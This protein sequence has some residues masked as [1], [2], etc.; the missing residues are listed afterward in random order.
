MK[1]LMFREYGNK[2]EMYYLNLIQRTA[3][4]NFVLTCCLIVG[5]SIFIIMWFMSIRGEK[6]SNS[7]QKQYRDMYEP[8]YQSLSYRIL[9]FLLYLM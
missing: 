7:W 8:E 4:E 2:K 9:K 1:E 3:N 5:F 6:K